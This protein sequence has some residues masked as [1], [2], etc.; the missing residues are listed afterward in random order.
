MPKFRRII[1]HN[2]LLWFWLAAIAGIVTPW[3]PLDDIMLARS[4][5]ECTVSS[6]YDGDTLRARCGTERVNV[7]FYCI[8][9]P[10]MKQRPWG[11]ESRDVLRR[12]VRDAGGRVTLSIRNTDRYGRS[13]AEVI[14]DGKNLNVE[15]VRQGR[16]A[17]YRRYCPIRERAYYRAQD[18]AKRAR[19]GIW[20]K[21]G[22]HQR[23]W[24]YRRT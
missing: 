22:M 23:P 8:D 7:R 18:E 9:A 13:V 12:M 20:S 4:A 3:L 11:P 1:T 10:E 21:P 2:R 16:A 24:E 15:M 6:V 17:V 5:E 14:A 19:R